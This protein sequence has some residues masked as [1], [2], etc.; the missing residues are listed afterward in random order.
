MLCSGA[1]A[2]AQAP[3]IANPTSA[4]RYAAEHGERER[5]GGDAAAGLEVWVYPLRI[6]HTGPWR[7]DSARFMLLMASSIS[8]A[9]LNPTVAQS[10]PAFWN[11]NLIAFTRSS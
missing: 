3:Y 1:S 6:L 4:L 2:C 8:C 9:P 5:L 7:Y 11:A 10:T